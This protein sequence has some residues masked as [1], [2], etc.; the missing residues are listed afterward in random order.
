MA[1]GADDYLLLPVQPDEL[2][3]ALGYVRPGEWAVQGRSKVPEASA[4]EIQAL[5]DVLARLE[6]EP[7][8]VL[9]RIAELVRVASGADGVTVAVEGS[10]ATCGDVAAKPVLVERVVVGD[11]LI[12]QISLTARAAGPYGPG[13]TEKLRHYAAVTGNLI[14][15]AQRHRHWYNLAMTDELSG[16][17]NRRYLLQFLDDIL[18]RA[19]EERFRVT[20]L[21]F[22]IDDFKLY[23]DTCG[24]E[25]GDEVI[26]L[27]AD[28]FKRHCR[29]H[30]LVTRYGGDEF[31]VVF[32]DA[33]E[34]RSAKS[35]HPDD[36]LTVLGRFTRELS[37]VEP[38][39]L[40][41]MP[42]VEL[43]ISGGLAT[44]PWDADNRDDL[45]R[46][47]DQAMIQAKRE[48]KNRIV[49]IGQRAAGQTDKT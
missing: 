10:A 13:D 23:N 29:E 35:E 49:T 12:G 16:L 8:V 42:N 7:M 33:E 43:T 41:D 11:Q 25:A 17:P 39:S 46:R 44:Y 20:L 4:A 14:R 15:A 19:M 22:D 45:I 27:A 5:A 6:A 3:R 24:H 37:A 1:Q 28:L 38:S 47:A 31:A 9:Q 26:R 32:W 48:G 2:D 18:A 36:A 34:P 21:I 40:K 30:D